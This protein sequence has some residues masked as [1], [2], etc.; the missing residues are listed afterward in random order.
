MQ[1]WIGEWSDPL[2]RFAYALTRSRDTAQ[3][4]AQ[5]TFFRLLVMHRE[6]PDRSI[7][8]A[9]LF[10][11]ARNLSLNMARQTIR[12]STTDTLQ[13]NAGQGD[14]LD[15]DVRLDI[16]RALERLPLPDRECLLLFYYGDLSLEELA[17][18]LHISPQS[19]KA[20]LHRARQRF[21][22]IWGGGNRHG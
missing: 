16:F 22:K 9:W 1:T 17:H 21:A 6:H 7:R 4:I 10:T 2:T 14:G 11:V 3:D 19:V 13:E 15:I 18:R 8:P 5:D 20:R 12:T